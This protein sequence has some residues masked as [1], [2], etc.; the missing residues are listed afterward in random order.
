MSWVFAILLVLLL[1]PEAYLALRSVGT[2]FHAAA[3]GVA[4]VTAVT[5]VR[6]TVR[7]I[8][9]AAE[10]NATIAAIACYDQDRCFINK[11]HFTLRKSFA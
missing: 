1:A 7:D 3:D 8:F 5:A 4:A 6:P 10:A 2:R 11:L 9:F